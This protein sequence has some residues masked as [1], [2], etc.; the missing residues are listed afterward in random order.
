MSFEVRNTTL[1]Y[2]LFSISILF[3]FNLIIL[4][5]INLYRQYYLD[6][7][8]VKLSFIRWLLLL[9]CIFQFQNQL[10]YFINN[11]VLLFECQSISNIL[12]FLMI[13]IYYIYLIYIFSDHYSNC[14]EYLDTISIIMHIK[15]RSQS[16]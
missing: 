3:S 7:Y 15:I 11:G 5:G 9:C 6:G 8:L 12:I 10:G 13:A 2:I 14:V 16:I 1:E 4:S